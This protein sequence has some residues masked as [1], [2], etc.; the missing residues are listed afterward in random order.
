M[1]TYYITAHRSTSTVLPPLDIPHKLKLEA[2]SDSVMTKKSTAS[3]LPTHP[4]SAKARTTPTKLNTSLKWTK[5]SLVSFN[6]RTKDGI[7]VKSLDEFAVIGHQLRTDVAVSDTHLFDGFTT[8]SNTR[9]ML[10]LGSDVDRTLSL[11][12]YATEQSIIEKG[13]ALH[14]SSSTR[15]QRLPRIRAAKGRKKVSRAVMTGMV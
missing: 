4:H 14:K 15:K 9:L 11:P 10:D 13:G 12:L 5:P 2:L 3:D 6:L 7:I 1:M 8:T